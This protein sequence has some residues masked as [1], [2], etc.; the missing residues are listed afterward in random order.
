MTMHEQ[1]FDHEVGGA[2]TVSLSDLVRSDSAS[3]RKM[4][5]ARLGLLIGAAGAAVSGSIRSLAQRITR[6]AS[7]W[8]DYCATEALYEHLSGLSDVQLR[9]RE[10]SRDSLARD[11]S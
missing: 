5:I 7:T 10:L 8:T 1:V 3:A 6:S 4:G 9:N 2:R 11:R